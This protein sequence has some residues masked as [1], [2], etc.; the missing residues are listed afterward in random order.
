M[1]VAPVLASTADG[2]VDAFALAVLLLA[3]LET[4]AAVS[5]VAVLA[6]LG[7]ALV[8]LVVRS[9]GWVGAL[10]E[11]SLSFTFARLNGGRGGF[12]SSW[13]WSWADDVTAASAAAAGAGVALAGPKLRGLAVG[14]IKSEAGVSETFA[15]MA[16]LML[17][18]SS[19]NGCACRG[20]CLIFKG[21]LG[22]NFTRECHP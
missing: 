6:G 13:P 12:A 4:V 18:L 19:D 22:S 9:L 15:S 2:L 3:L 21:C 7:G 8:V 14:T 10:N 16:A 11:H 5:S 17:A 20:S 1:S